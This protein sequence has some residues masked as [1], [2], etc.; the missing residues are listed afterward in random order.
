MR[1][2][3]PDP[4]ERAKE[5]FKTM[6]L[7]KL[8]ARTSDEEPAGIVRPGEMYRRYRT[9]EELP[10]NA[11]A[12]YEVAGKSLF[13]GVSGPQLTMVQRE[14]LGSLFKNWYAVSLAQ[15]FNWRNGY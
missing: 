1:I 12:F 15:K 9:V 10:E 14:I 4:I 5:V 2:V 6:N 8:I 11:K 3:D 13:S 7:Q